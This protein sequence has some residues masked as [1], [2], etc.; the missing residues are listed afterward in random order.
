M[1]SARP[2][3]YRAR[4]FTP[5]ATV[6]RV[7]SQRRWL[8]GCAVIIVAALAVAT[9]AFVAAARSTTGISDGRRDA[10]QTATRD[11]VE[12]LM[13]FSPATSAQ[14]RTDVAARLTGRLAAEYRSRGPDVVL[15]GARQSNVTMSAKVVGVGVR[16]DDR[17]DAGE[18]RML[19]FVDQTVTVPG[20]VASQDPAQRGSTAKWAFMRN[21][22]GTWRL[23]DLTPVNS[24]AGGGTGA[25]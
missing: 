12:R 3:G 11:A 6:R 10:L 23:A 19:V 8:I 2:A 24:V 20:A 21:V 7:R 5:V 25:G 22:E 14:H 18:T 4:P 9:V 16:T 15:P 17:D 1:A 13:T